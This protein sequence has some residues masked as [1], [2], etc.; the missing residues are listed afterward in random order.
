[1]N[2]YLILHFPLIGEAERTFS[3]YS[4]IK[5][6]GRFSLD[7]VT[8]SDII[9]V[10][11]NGVKNLK[12]FNAYLYAREFITNRARVDDTMTRGEAESPEEPDD[13]EFSIF[14]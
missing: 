11:F 12:Y 1:M 3:F 13:D 7:P 6:R 8:V 9:R 2:T 5:T 14:R 4:R 10:K